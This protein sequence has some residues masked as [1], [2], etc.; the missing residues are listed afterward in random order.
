MARVPD[1]P[2]AR[3]WVGDQHPAGRIERHTSARTGRVDGSLVV[4][5]PDVVDEAVA[6]ARAAQRS[7]AAEP[8]EQRATVLRR[9]ADL[10]R[11]DGPTLGPLGTLE[12]GLAVQVTATYPDRAASYLDHAAATAAAVL[13]EESVVPE[14]G[15]GTVVVRRAPVGVVAA[16]MTWNGG[17]SALCRKLGPIL[18]T[19]NAA[20]VKTSELA[21]FSA[22]RLAQL[23]L[24]AGLPA[25]V[26]NVVHGGRDVGEHL[27][28]ARGVDKIS[29]TGS[30]VAG[31][32]IAARAG[33]RMIPGVYELGGKGT[34]L[35]RP[36]AELA[37]VAPVLAG[38]AFTMAGQG[39]VLPSRVL[40]PRELADELCERLDDLV[41]QVRVGDPDDPG[42]SV[43][44]LVGAAA[45]D[46]FRAAIDAMT[47]AGIPVARAPLDLPADLVGGAFVAP[48]VARWPRA[49]GSEPGFVAERTLWDEEVFGPLLCVAPVADDT[50]AVAAFN[51]GR[52]RLAA[53]VFG[54]D[55]GRAAAVAEQLDTA[56]TS[57]NGFA[58][59]FP[60][61][62]FGGVGESGY[63]REC[64]TDGLAEFVRSESCYLA[65]GTRSDHEGET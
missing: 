32:A 24:E 18:A 42:T 61:V 60:D 26:L 65:S 31:R 11:A 54:R 1:G 50:E 28:G 63:G 35:I 59:V 37:A 48:A 40:V 9:L 30:A 56:F 20:V 45:A 57:V 43:G 12:S 58:P 6:A 33:A 15:V 62:P 27:V 51:A 39:C 16:V 29:F 14:G 25:G 52:Y 2:T 49:H 22:D 55:P 38:L 64:G 41:A 46:R 8:L 36:D 23:A 17:V 4:A 34:C 47:R 53:Y 7:W 10:L 13:R 21:P 3:A 19:G 5:D 44:P